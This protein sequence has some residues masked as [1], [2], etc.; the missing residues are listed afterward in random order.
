MKF[1]GSCFHINDLQSL[2]VRRAWIEI[3]IVN[4]VLRLQAA[5]LSVRRAWIEIV[6]IF[7]PLQQ[8]LRSLSVRRA[9]IEIRCSRFPRAWDPVALREESV[10]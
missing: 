10:D 7:V 8:I 1:N 2:S 5:S 9:W 4:L 3:W 6:W